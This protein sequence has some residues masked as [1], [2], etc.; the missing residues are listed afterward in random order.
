[1]LLPQNSVST[2]MKSG[3]SWTGNGGLVILP[4]GSL[5]LGRYDEF[6]PLHLVSVDPLGSRTLSLPHRAFSSSHRWDIVSS[7]AKLPACHILI[8]EISSC[9]R[10]ITLCVSF[11]NP[12]IATVSADPTDTIDNYAKNVKADAADMPLGRSV[13]LDLTQN[14][15]DT[16]AGGGVCITGYERS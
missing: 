2:Y 7:S 3:V 4:I 11:S 15:S 14:Y 6:C 10:F 5:K 13:A 16:V 12:A 1:M 9:G 8:P